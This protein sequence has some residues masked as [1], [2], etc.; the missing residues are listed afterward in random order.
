MEKSAP[1]RRRADPTKNCLSFE[2]DGVKGLPEAASQT[3]LRD[4]ERIGMSGK[5]E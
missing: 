3:S 1:V 4:M 2:M 5:G